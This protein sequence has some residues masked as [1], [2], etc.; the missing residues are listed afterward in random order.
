MVDASE[1]MAAYKARGRSVAV[2]NLRKATGAKSR[3]TK[4]NKS[5]R[6]LIKQLKASIN[7]PNTN[8]RP[9][10]KFLKKLAKR[11]QDLGVS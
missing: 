8:S 11:T 5:F 7:Y 4:A 6:I 3:S 1:L 9:S 2:L 10:K